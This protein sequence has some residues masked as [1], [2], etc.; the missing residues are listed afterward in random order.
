MRGLL[1]ALPVCPTALL[2]FIYF[3]TGVQAPLPGAR[4]RLRGRSRRSPG[5]SPWQ[6]P[7]APISRR[8]LQARER[9]PDTLSELL[10]AAKPLPGSG[11]AGR[12]GLPRSSETRCRAGKH[13]LEIGARGGCQGESPGDRLD[14]PLNL[15]QAPGRGAWTSV[16]KS[17]KTRSAVGQTGKAPS[18]PLN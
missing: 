13:L 5:L 12:E 15:L 10:P 2:V 4:S 17:M 18:N 16:K 6:P 11:F 8:C 14:L 1:G 7:L 3:F 9:A